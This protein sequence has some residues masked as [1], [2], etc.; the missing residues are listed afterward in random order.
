MS[1][2]QL[3]GLQ[4]DHRSDIFS[5]G[6]IVYEML[7]GKRAFQ[8]DTYADTVSSI[9]KEDPPELTGPNLRIPPQLGSLLHHCLEKNPD[10]RFQSVRDLA[11]GLKFISGASNSTIT[12]EALGDREP[13]PREGVLRSRLALQLISVAALIMIAGAVGWWS[14]RRTGTAT[15]RPPVRVERLTDYQGME[16]YPAVSP[17]GKSVAFSADITGIRQIW[18][19]LIAG[20]PPLQL[21]HDPMDH[22]SPR[23]FPNLSS[24]L[25][26]T[27]PKEVEGEGALWEVSSLGGAPRRLASS[28]SEGD[29]SHDGAKLAF[30][31]LSE[32]HTQLVVT[33]QNGA[34]ARV[35]FRSKEHQIYASPR[36]SPNDHWIAFE[37]TSVIWAYDVFVVPS[38]GGEPRLVIHE[39]NMLSGF[40]WEADGKGII[41]STA[42]ESTSLYLPRMSLWRLDI[43]GGVAQQ[44]TFD[45]ASYEG[46]DVDREGT[47]FASRMRMHFDLWKYPVAGSP[48]ENVKNGVQLT[49]QTA[50]VQTP[51][52]SPD[53]KEIA[54]L[55]DS[56]GHGN[57]WVINLANAELRQ[58]TFE[59]DPAETIGTPVWSPDGAHIA[60]ATITTFDRR[61]SS[62][63]RLVNP[64]GSN[65]RVVIPN[66]S[67][68]T[69]SGDSRWLYYSAILPGHFNGDMLMKQAIDGGAPVTVRSDQPMA[70]TVSWDGTGLFYVVPL[71]EVSGVIDYD[72]RFANPESGPAKVL[73]RIPGLR[74]PYWQG[75]Q[76]VLSHSGKWLAMPLNGSLGTNLWLLPSTGGKLK[77]VTDF[78]PLRTFIARRVSWS[79]DDRFIFVSLGVGD[80]DI[81]SISGLLP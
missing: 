56:G 68:A 23:W 46:P 45:E 51:T 39:N 80:A 28:V 10:E 13:R 7:S 52:P 50:Q 19:R 25:Y 47:V 40:A 15:S 34:N 78:S 26:Y 32:G 55:S 70:P 62:E 20:G 53:D 22:T 27:P 77:Q 35:V 44:L 74:I 64:D 5:L 71:Q 42:R 59:R 9:L 65:P 67:W 72:I 12:S 18:V 14:A 76:P 60:Y 79:A 43:S 58:I 17:D 11:F 8:R 54:F 31:R 1:P 63:Y 6:A 29:I 61:A 66:G 36:W 73:A 33:D 4:V 48:L 69:W 2:E 41:Y 37:N 24:I 57:I 30:F 49:H 16:E 75:L 3:R 81:V 38:D 21:T